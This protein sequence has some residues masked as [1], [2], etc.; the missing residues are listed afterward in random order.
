MDLLTLL[1]TAWALA[2]DAFA[3]AAVVS[4]GLSCLTYRHT[5]RLA[6]HFGLFQAGM[7]IIGW[8]GGTAVS[9]LTAAFAHWLAAGL[10]AFIGL[11][12]LRESFKREER[13]RD[14]DPTKGW[15]LVGLS[16]ATSIDALAIG[17]SFGLINLSIWFP[18]FVIGTVTIVI[19]TIGVLVGR[20]AG[21]FLGPWAEG[22]GGIV[23]VI[24]SLRIVFQ[25]LAG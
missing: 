10:L 8:F 15:S 18:A 24:I 12:M 16:V 14:F 21:G 2:M 25:H 19:T 3:V 11:R 7:P 22:F 17:M 13:T 20:K 9:S 5:F 1:G 23:L 6:W 4:A